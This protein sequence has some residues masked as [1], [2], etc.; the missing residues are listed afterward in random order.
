[1]NPAQAETTGEPDPAEQGEI[2]DEINLVSQ[3]IEEWFK[4]LTPWEQVIWKLRFFYGVDVNTIGLL[5]R[6]ERDITQE[7]MKAMSPTLHALHGAGYRAITP[8]F[9]KFVEF[10]GPKIA[11]HLNQFKIT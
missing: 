4:T 3:W 6:G 8:I 11:R 2:Q 10:L 9:I 5:V 1:M 7:D